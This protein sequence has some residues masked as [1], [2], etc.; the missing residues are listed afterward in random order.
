MGYSFVTKRLFTARCNGGDSMFI[1]KVL[2][3][4]RIKNNR[5]IIET[6]YYTLELKTVSNINCNGNP[7]FSCLIKEHVL[8]I[9]SNINYY[10]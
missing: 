7:V 10:L 8:K 2:L 9:Y 3:S 5:I 4:V 6:L 1:D